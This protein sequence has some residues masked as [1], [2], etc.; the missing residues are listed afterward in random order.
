MVIATSPARTLEE[1]LKV[2]DIRSPVDPEASSRWNAAPRLNRLEGKT[3]GFLGNKKANS[4]LLL[5][6]VKDLMCQR[7]ELGEGIAVD[8][9]IYSRPAA[10]DIIES[11]ADRCDFVVTAIAD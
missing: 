10:P 3:G 4:G 7:L 11:L 5:E 1:R 8:K 6:A 2:L 9:Y